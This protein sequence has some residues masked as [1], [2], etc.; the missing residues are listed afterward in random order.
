MSTTTRQFLLPLSGAAGHG[1]GP[2]W[3]PALLP[4]PAVVTR[5]LQRLPRWI[6]GWLIMNGSSPAHEP[7]GA[8]NAPVIPVLGASSR[9]FET[10]SFDAFTSR[11]MRRTFAPPHALPSFRRRY[12]LPL[13]PS[14][15]GCEGPAGEPPWPAGLE[16]RGLDASGGPRQH[17]RC[18]AGP[19]SPVGLKIAGRRVVYMR[20]WQ[21]G[22]VAHRGSCPSC[23]P[24]VQ[25]PAWRD[26]AVPVGGWAVGFREPPV[27]SA[28]KPGCP[29][30]LPYVPRC[31]G[32]SE[33][34]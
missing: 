4:R 7:R 27:V 28:V 1:G 20:G 29:W 25:V 32:P 34:R 12:I 15:V 16:H 9:R 24:T 26:G 21:T 11:E 2:F 10:A 18:G 17:P 30:S 23:A 31:R 14:V 8:V 5:R 22:G 33:W 13:H 3:R 19:E 6:C